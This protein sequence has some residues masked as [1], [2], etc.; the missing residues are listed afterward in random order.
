MTETQDTLIA[1]LDS[2]LEIE[3][4]ALIVGNIAKLADIVEEKE[5]LIAVLSEMDFGSNTALENVNSK[6][7]RNQAL[8]EQ[9]LDGIRSVAK[10]LADIRR[11]RREFDTYN[12]LGKRKT[13]EAE[14]DTS[15]EKRA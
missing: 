14:T 1:K 13:I 3:R 12:Q 9:A 4:E 5:H 11:N 10:K 6:V 8:L 2:L 15:V 7:M